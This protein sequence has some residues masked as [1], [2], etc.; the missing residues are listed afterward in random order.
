IELFERRVW[1]KY[2]ESSRAVT[3]YTPHMLQLLEFQEKMERTV[4]IIVGAASPTNHA[5]TVVGVERFVKWLVTEPEDKIRRYLEL[6]LEERLGALEFYREYAYENGARFFCIWG[7]ARTWGPNHLDKFGYVDR[8]FAEEVG[9]IFPYAFWHQCGKNLP[10]AMEQLA[11]W[12]GIKAVQYDEPY[13]F[14][15]IPWHDWCEW[16]AKLFSG[17]KCAMNAPTTQRACFGTPD[18][19]KQMVHE[20][21]EATLPYTTAVVMPGCEI[22][23]Y[24]PV[25]NV[26]AIIEATRS[27]QVK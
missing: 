22:D 5:E 12:K 7:G 20:F 23:S 11:D 16:V 4:P 25:E 8:I 27:T 19:I 18:E 24:A 14:Q 6:V 1:E 21:I 15:D 26:R 10:Y 2:G 9:K 13:Y 17:K 3:H